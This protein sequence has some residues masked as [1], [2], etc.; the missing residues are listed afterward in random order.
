ML[1]EKLATRVSAVVAAVC[2][3]AFAAVALFSLL[4]FSKAERASAEEAARGQ[5]SAVVD[6]LELTSKSH[7][8]A[9]MKRLGV[10][11]TMLGDTLKAADV[12]TEKDAF[13]LPVFRVAGEVVNAN[14]RLMARWKEILIAEPALLLLNS[15][16]EMVRVAT[17]L[18]DKEGKSMV[19]KPI[20]A[21]APETLT[22]LEGKEWSGVVQRGG[23]FYVSAFLPLKNAQGKVL[24]AWSVRSDVS[25]DMGRL[26][27]TLKKMKFGDTGYPYAIKIEKN[28]DDS[29]LT[30]HPKLEGKTAREV[31]GPL[32]MLAARMSAKDEG[33][34]VY[35]YN[36]ETGREREK[37]VVFKRS[38][39]W[40]WTVAGGTWIDE[41]NKNASSIRLQL[42]FACLLG[43]VLC[44]LAAWF[45]AT[46]GLA[47]VQPVV[48]GVRR[49]GAG[50][51]SQPIPSASCEIGIIAHEANTA[52]DNIGRL[53]GNISSASATAFSSAKSLEQA[54]LAATSSADEQ[55]ASAAEL[56]T[57]IEQLS[58]SISHTANQTRQSAN[59]AGET[60]ALAQ[61]GTSAANSVSAEM[62]KIAQE[63]ASAEALMAQ[64]A[65]NASEIAGMASSISELA[66]QTNLLALNAA[67]EAARAG[68]AGRGFAVVADEV[69]K[70]AE[71]STQ[72]T[73]RIAQTVSATSSGT[74]RA[75]E[76][77]KQIAQ[78]AQE[79]RRL[80][81]DAETALGAIAEAGRRSVEASTEIASAA[82]QQGATSHTIS[83]AVERIAEGAELNS[84]QARQLLGE[85]R[86]LEGVAR[87]LEQ[88]AASFRT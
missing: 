43:A 25:E 6:L 15:Q 68:E 45:A 81:A 33:T 88:S 87:G 8:A 7:E 38:P 86:A 13:G 41:Y 58:E 78:Q 40:G 61:Q 77:A 12:S 18:K 71:K 83:Q 34:I 73:N 62:H 46:R 80:A 79:A 37:I 51:F 1:S 27:E 9:G 44:A 49:M 64:L 74:A 53:I 23:K 63:T 28:T 3:I 82:Q 30:L 26:N 55:S 39:S 66:D 56:A 24:G 84:N 32:P 60:L 19:G 67:I 70:L 75:A 65:V 22:V 42:G 31:Q 35:P 21:N 69:R 54:A 36:D 59:A 4:T 85:V 50:D 5:V 76:A 48:E 52:R 2:A 10:L 29:F 47:G 14:E 11:K 57:A 20:A 17:L 72:F 16:G